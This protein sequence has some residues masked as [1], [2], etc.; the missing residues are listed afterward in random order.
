VWT[1]TSDPD[2]N[3]KALERERRLVDEL[4]ARYAE[5]SE[6]WRGIYKDLGVKSTSALF[7]SGLAT[8]VQ[9]GIVPI[10]TVV[11][12]L[13]WLHATWSGAVRPFRRRPAGL[14][15]QLENQSSPNPVRRAIDAIERRL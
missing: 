2:L 1:T 8:V 14:L 5:A 12:A 15:V 4:T 3:P 13:A 9:S 6:E 7:A 11:T 10:A